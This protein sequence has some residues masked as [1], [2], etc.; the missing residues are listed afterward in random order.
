MQLVII[1]FVNNETYIAHRLMYAESFN[2]KN[3]F[4]AS[5]AFSLIVTRAC[6]RMLLTEIVFE[7]KKKE[8]KTCTRDALSNASI[9]NYS[10][11]FTYYRTRVL[12]LLSPLGSGRYCKF[13]VLNFAVT[14]FN[15]KVIHFN[16]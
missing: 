11:R 10:N 1:I 3:F 14:Y 12:T 5:C 2:E 8:R 6:R 4:F 7:K 15:K 16:Y 9:S 13:F